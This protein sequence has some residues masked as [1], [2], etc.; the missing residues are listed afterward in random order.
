MRHIH[1]HAQHHHNPQGGPLGT[2]PRYHHY[3]PAHGHSTP[4][5]LGG[6]ED[7][8]PALVVVGRTQAYD[9]A[10]LLRSE[11]GAYRPA[12]PLPL[13]RRALTYG[14]W[15][16]DLLGYGVKV[17]KERGMDGGGRVCMWVGGLRRSNPPL[18]TPATRNHHPQ[19][20]TQLVAVLLFQTLGAALIVNEYNHSGLVSST[21]LRFAGAILRRRMESTDRHNHNP[22]HPSINNKDTLIHPHAFYL[23]IHL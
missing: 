14:H 15:A 13:R 10:A 6:D 17:S 11:F 19:N 16:V 2:H 22:L 1:E 5:P 21:L 4:S 23:S 7:M 18:L 9:A 8:G 3:T 12:R 20:K